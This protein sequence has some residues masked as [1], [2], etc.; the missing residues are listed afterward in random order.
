MTIIITFEC[1]T[2]RGC[3]II[4]FHWKQRG[5]RD[6]AILFLRSPLTSS[7]PDRICQGSAG[8]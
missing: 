3:I 7:F 5:G 2:P 6:P 8:N 1:D 4:T